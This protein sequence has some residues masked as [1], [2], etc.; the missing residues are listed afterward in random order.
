M[1]QVRP[2]VLGDGPIRAILKR[3][4]KIVAKFE[5]LAR[6]RGEAVVFPF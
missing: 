2:W 5:T 3:R 6:E 4:D 1:K